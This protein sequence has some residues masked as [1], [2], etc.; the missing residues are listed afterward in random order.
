[1]PK[2]L[3]FVVGGWQLSGQFSIQSGVPVVFGTDSFFS[4]Q[5][6]ALR[7]TSRA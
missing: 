1:M 4:G 5:D 6:F 7:R 2:A 3:D